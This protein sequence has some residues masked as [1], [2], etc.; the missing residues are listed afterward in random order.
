[1]NITL[2]SAADGLREL[3]EQ[4]DPETG[5]LPEG[6]QDAR[7]LVASK[8]IACAAFVL[9]NERQADMVQDHAKALLERVKIARKRSERLK[10]YLK[11]H[12]VSCGMTSIKSDDG[13]LSV[14][15]DRERDS[16]VEIFDE[17]QIPSDYM[18]E[19]PASFSPDKSLIKKA[20]G[21]GFTVDGARIVKAD[22]LTIK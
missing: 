13:L 10:D 12:M 1:M 4:I 7:A 3:L 16:S 9:E 5:E 21:D 14:K 15:L 18:R 8:S 11:Y 19:I 17:K 2:Y 20:I 22:R 6:F